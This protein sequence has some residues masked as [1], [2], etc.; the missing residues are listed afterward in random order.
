MLLL[1]RRIGQKTAEQSVT[2]FLC[3]KAAAVKSILKLV[4][5][6]LFFAD[7]LVLE[8]VL[9]M[10]K[11]I[12]DLSEAVVLFILCSHLISIISQTEGQNVPS[13]KSACLPN[14]ICLA[15]TQKR[16]HSGILCL[17]LKGLG[18]TFSCILYVFNQHNCKT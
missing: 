9:K 12:T 10:D 11:L 5:E 15:H 18:L 8:V 17:I 16:H 6:N 14:C 7:V 4:M 13:F 2:Y 3:R 1:R